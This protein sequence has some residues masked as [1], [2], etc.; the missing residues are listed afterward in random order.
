MAE[1]DNPLATWSDRTAQIVE[2][3]ASS[4]VAVH[5]G[6]RLSSRRSRHSIRKSPMQ[7]WSTLLLTSR[8]S[9][10]KILSPPSLEEDTGARSRCAAAVSAI[11]AISARLFGKSC[12]HAFLR[13]PTQGQ[14]GG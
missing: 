12:S 9:R 2:L 13:A 14:K 5:G 6:S 8:W 1:A 3:A 7:Q 4:I 11:S 10:P